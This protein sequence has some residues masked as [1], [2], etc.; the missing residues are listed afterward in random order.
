M[1]QTVT[2]K[3]GRLMGWRRTSITHVTQSVNEWDKAEEPDVPYYS[4][5]GTV[6]LEVSFAQ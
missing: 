2:R 3:R 6:L 5:Y 4:M 1:E